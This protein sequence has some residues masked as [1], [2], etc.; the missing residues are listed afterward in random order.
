MLEAYI[1]L[2]MKKCTA[3]STLLTQLS[4]ICTTLFNLRI[5]SDRKEAAYATAVPQFG[6]ANEKAWFQVLFCCYHTIE[7]PRNQALS[8]NK[9]KRTQKN[10]NQYLDAVLWKI[11][12]AKY[13]K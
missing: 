9:K 3:L 10:Y 12:V 2:K 7:K 8:H 4:S 6:A 13:S 5:R 1:E 11:K